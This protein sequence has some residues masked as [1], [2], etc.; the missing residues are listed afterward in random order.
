MDLQSQLPSLFKLAT[1]VKLF[2]R[3]RIGKGIVVGACLAAP[4]A[5]VS[6][7]WMGELTRLH[8][9]EER[10]ETMR[11]VAS[12]SSS[13]SKIWEDYVSRYKEASPYFIEQVV[14]KHSFH[15]R[16]QERL[17]TLLAL[18]M[19]GSN[20]RARERLSFLSGEKN[21]IQFAEQHPYEN[22]KWKEVMLKQLRPVSIGEEDAGPLLELVEGRVKGS[23]QLTITSCRMERIDGH[24]EFSCECL[25]R[26]MK[27]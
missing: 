5:L 15:K 2:F 12:R 20:E 18:P 21:A 11:M 3:S 23:P 7:Y 6:F 27:K 26:E 14:E 10:I 22:G 8:E 24:V 9:A 19:F 13:N 25:K 1:Q 17:Q 16:E 4:V